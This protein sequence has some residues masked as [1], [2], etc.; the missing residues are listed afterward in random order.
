MS[1][2]NYEESF[3]KAQKNGYFQVV[4]FSLLNDQSNS[5]DLNNLVN[6]T[7]SKIND[8][9][10]KEQVSIMHK[11]PNDKRLIE[12]PFRIDNSI[13]FTINRGTIDIKEIEELFN[14]AITE[15]GLT[16]SFNIS[17]ALYTSDDW[18]VFSNSLCSR[19]NCIKY[20]MDHKQKAYQEK[21]LNLI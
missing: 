4:L 10:K 15:L 16:Y 2:Y 3:R 8:Y 13:G 11:V 12:D 19:G 6:L 7:I 14:N 9:E 17:S 20:L 18:L 1:L 21:K 5:N